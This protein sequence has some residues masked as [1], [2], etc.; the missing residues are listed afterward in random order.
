MNHFITNIHVN[1]LFH[2]N[3][4]DIP[5]ADEKHPHLIITGKNGSGKTVLLNSLADFLG[6]IK[7]DTNMNFSTYEKYLNYWTS[8][9]NKPSATQTEKMDAKQNSAYYSELFNNLYGKVNIAINDIGDIIEK[10]QKGQFV[11]AFYEA[12]RVVKM[13][14]PKNPTKPQ[15]N[16]KGKV[17]ETATSQFLNFLSDLKIQE[18]LARNEN[19]DK[20]ADKIGEWFNDFRKLLQDVYQ[21]PNLTLEFNYKDYSFHICTEGK[22]FKFTEVSDGFSAILDIIADL[23]LKMQGDNS[24]SN[25]YQK[26]GIVLIDEI[27]THL[28]LGLQKAILPLLTKLFPNIQFIVTTHSPFVLN[29]IPNAVAYDLEHREILED[30][31]EYSYEALAEGYFG[32]KTPSSYVEMQLNNLHAL[33]EKN[34]WSNSDK[35]S[36][37]QLISDFDKIPETVSPLIVG[38]Y[39]QLAVKYA[40][41]I[42]EL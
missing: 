28:H 26:E 31:T 17:K 27:E 8:R 37:K 32:V 39:R 16:K 6:I 36:I 4:F 24:V 42:K 11:I 12:A 7:E 38:E 33:L 40:N 23:I 29:S 22:R 15:Y 21:D 5:I 2:L 25:E 9:I 18:A 10:Y 3:N 30:L 1:K 34:D 13:S 20:D 14:E 41:R 19:Q 35:V